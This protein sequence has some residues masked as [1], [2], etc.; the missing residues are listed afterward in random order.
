MFGACIEIVPAGKYGS[1]NMKAFAETCVTGTAIA[2]RPYT[3]A[4]SPNNMIFPGAE[5]EIAGMNTYFM[6]Q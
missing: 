3:T 4:C 2:G 6:D 1:G 5:A